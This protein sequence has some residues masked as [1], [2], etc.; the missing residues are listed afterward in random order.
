MQ[1]SDDVVAVSCNDTIKRKENPNFSSFHYT[2]PT[3]QS[4]ALLMPHLQHCI[5]ALTKLLL[6]HGQRGGGQG[7]PGNQFSE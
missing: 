6:P 4:F 2:I 5:A 7:G 1:G 3:Y